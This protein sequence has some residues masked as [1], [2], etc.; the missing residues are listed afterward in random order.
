MFWVVRKLHKKR[1]RIE[2]LVERRMKHVNSRYKQQHAISFSNT[3]IIIIQSNLTV[4]RTTR[5]IIGEPFQLLLIN[6]RI[7]HVISNMQIHLY[8]LLT[9]DFFHYLKYLNGNLISYFHSPPHQKYIFIL[10]K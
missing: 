1:P 5:H 9:S 8:S 4:L 7:K 10:T 2:F 3:S 6:I